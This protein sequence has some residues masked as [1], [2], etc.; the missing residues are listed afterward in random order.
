MELHYH[1]Y[2]YYYYYYYTTTTTIL[3]RSTTT[4]TTT[5]TIQV[6]ELH[7]FVTPAEAA[8]FQR[9][10]KPHFERSLAGDQ[11]NPVRT[12]FQCWCNFP[13]CFMDEDVHRVTRRIN[14]VTGTNFDNGEDIQ[15]VRY[16]PGQFYKVHHDQ[17]TAVWAP[18]GPRVLTFFMYL[19][20]PE[21]G[22]ETWF[23]QVTNVNG[24]RGIMV[25]PK[26]GSAILWPSTLDAA[27][28]HADHRTNHA[29]QPVT[30]GIK[31]AANM[32][33]HQFDFKTPSERG[34]QL[35]YVNTVGNVPRDP[36]HIKLT[37]GYV[38]D[39]ETDGEPGL[40]AS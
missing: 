39:Y 5:T 15:I 24:S 28:M 2:Y 3:L 8:A 22:G 13:G 1:Y 37:K 6:V 14:H 25:Q 9:V 17:N 11:L 20:T 38:P 21:G 27:P 26:A 23:P 10:C 19:N 16:E 12:S 31:F 30:Q 40:R 32:W 33:I 7:D 35:T 29:A 36:E 34:C 18:Q 4:T